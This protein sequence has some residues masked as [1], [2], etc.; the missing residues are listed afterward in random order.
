MEIEW[1]KATLFMNPRAGVEV[2]FLYAS[3]PG[4]FR[5]IILKEQRNKGAL[6]C[7]RL[8]SPPAAISAPNFSRST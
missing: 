3:T 5:A 4:A 7:P 8:P 1:E 2:L 6:Y